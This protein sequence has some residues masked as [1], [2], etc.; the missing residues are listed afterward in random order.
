M[1]KTICIIIAA[2]SIVALSLSYQVFAE[3]G[4]EKTETFYY[5][6][7]EITVTT[8]DDFSYEELQLIADQIAY[9]DLTPSGGLEGHSVNSSIFCTLFGHSIKTATAVEVTHNAYTT[10]PKCLQKTYRVETCERNN[11]DYYV[12]T[13]ISSK[14]IS[15]CHG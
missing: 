13:L 4:T 10:S 9:G 5:E 2:V 3:D 8:S 14:R 11:C 1:K 15:T 12:K 6:G 7:K